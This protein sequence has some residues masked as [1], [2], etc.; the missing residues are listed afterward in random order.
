M[1]TPFNGLDVGAHSSPTVGDYDFDGDVDVMIGDGDGS[2]V[3]VRNDGGIFTPLLST[4]NPMEGLSTG[5]F[6]KPAFYD[7]NGDGKPDVLSG[8]SETDLYVFINQ[9]EPNNT[10]DF[11]DRV[12][13]VYPN[14]TSAIISIESPWNDGKHSI[15]KVFN[16]LGQCILTQENVGPSHTLSVANIPTGQYTVVLQNGNQQSINKIV[17]Q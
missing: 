17:K 1:N 14:P 6:S 4:E 15:L 8:S 9:I 5:G 2:F 3:T 12:S 16:Q 13:V 11:E 7:F 10:I